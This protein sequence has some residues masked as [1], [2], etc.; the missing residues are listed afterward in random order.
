VF[1]KKVV[2]HGDGNDIPSPSHSHR[3]RLAG[4]GARIETGVHGSGIV[5]IVVPASA[6]G[7][8]S[9][10]SGEVGGPRHTHPSESVLPSVGTEIIIRNLHSVYQL[11]FSR[12]LLR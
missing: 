8:A 7:A 12:R 10:V 5:T 6:I 11:G 2:E 4:L 3:K 1:T 9:S